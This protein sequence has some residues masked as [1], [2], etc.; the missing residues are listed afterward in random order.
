MKVPQTGNRETMELKMTPMIDVVF[1]LL[2]F[3]VWTSSFELPEFDLPSAIAETP[4]GGTSVQSQAAPAEA[5][6]ELIVRLS[7]R[8]GQLLIRFNEA[9]IDTVADLGAQLTKIISIGVQPPIIIDP[10]DDVT[11][12]DAVR[13]YDAARDAGADRVLFAADPES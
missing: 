11:M 13:V 9:S 8:E 4:S 6:D 2:V 5:F 1:L 7:T 10:D 3:F 12:N